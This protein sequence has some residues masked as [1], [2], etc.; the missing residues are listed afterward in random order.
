M[1]PDKVRAAVYLV[2]FTP[3]HL[4]WSVGWLTGRLLSFGCLVC[5]FNDD[6]MMS[7]RFPL[8]RLFCLFIYIVMRFCC[9]RVVNCV[10]VSSTLLW[11]YKLGKAGFHMT[12]GT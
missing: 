4:P 7:R 8:L 5:I 10:T 1:G 6:G 12:R 11:C 2:T 9:G 3:P